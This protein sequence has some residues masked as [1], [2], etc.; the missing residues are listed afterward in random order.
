MKVPT[1]LV[2]GEGDRL[3]PV[4]QAPAWA[5]LLPSATIRTFKGAGHLVLDERPES[6]GAV[7]EFLA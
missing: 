3:V 4:G 2:W 5:K 6:V 7:T 1:L